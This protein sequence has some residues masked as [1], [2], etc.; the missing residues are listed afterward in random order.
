MPSR[1]PISVAQLN[2]GNNS[3]KLKWNQTTIVFSERF[4]KISQNNL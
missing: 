2:A 1:L 4:K 3:E